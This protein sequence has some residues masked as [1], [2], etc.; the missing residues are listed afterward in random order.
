MEKATRSMRC[1]CNDPIACGLWRLRTEAHARRQRQK[2]GIAPL[3]RSAG[4]SSG[5]VVHLELDGMG[6]YAEARDLLHLE[7]DVRIDHVV[8]EDSAPREEGAVLVE[9][10]ERLV[11]RGARMRHLRRLLGLE[12]VEVLVERIARVDLVLHAV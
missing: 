4:R 2:R 8:G 3:L 5:R 7:R 1:R 9:R 10:L 11:E 6:G 12:V